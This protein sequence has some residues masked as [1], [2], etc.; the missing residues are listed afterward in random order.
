M[1]INSLILIVLLM[2][3]VGCVGSH[4]V[5]DVSNFYNET[6]NRYSDGKNALKAYSAENGCNGRNA[7]SV[8]NY[9]K[10]LEHSQGAELL[11]SRY[12][13]DLIRNYHTELAFGYADVALKKGCLDDA[14]NVY[15]GLISFY[16]G[17]AYSGIRDRAKL[18]IDDIRSMRESR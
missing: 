9:I 8:K 16:V 12:R 10:M 17:D 3:N 11:Y 4:Q 14:D 5:N 6:S 18:G 1:F 13:S 15:R 2:L 7:D